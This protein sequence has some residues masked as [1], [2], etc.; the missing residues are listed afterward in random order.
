MDPAARWAVL[1]RLCPRC[2]AGLEHEASEWAH[3]DGRPV[4]WA[5]EDAIARMEGHDQA[6][7]TLGRMRESARIYCC[8]A[9]CGFEIR[10]HQGGRFWRHLTGGLV[11]P[12]VMAAKVSR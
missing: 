5:I 4:D 1:H 2:R 6:Y 9:G 10:V 7:P 12:F 11:A 8:V 3:L